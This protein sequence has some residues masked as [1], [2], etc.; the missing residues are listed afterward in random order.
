MA[1]TVQLRSGALKKQRKLLFLF[2]AIILT[3]NLFNKK[4]VQ[5]TAF[6]Y[7]NDFLF[8]LRIVQSAG[9]YIHFGFAF[10]AGIV[11]FVASA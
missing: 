10:V 3:A 7:K 8:I 2:Y 1:V 11:Q 9:R 6:L 4:A 5:W